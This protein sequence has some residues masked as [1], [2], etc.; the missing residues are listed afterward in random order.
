MLIPIIYFALG[1]LGPISAEQYSYWKFIP[2]QKKTAN[3]QETVAQGYGWRLIWDAAYFMVFVNAL[4]RIVALTAALS[5]FEWLGYLCFLCGVLL[6]IWSLKEIGRFY[7]PGIALKADH[8]MIRTGPYRVLRHPL[9]L[10]TLLQIA[11]L[12]SFAP[13][14]L[15]LPVVLAALALCL[16]LNRT[17]DRAHAQQLGPAF[18]VYYL[19]TWDMIDLIIWKLR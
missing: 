12:A 3:A 7:D 8:Q 13:V 1:I 10:G 2:K 6:R 9:H 18:K 11:G 19:Q 17:E 4:Y 5:I 14:W 16:Y 15:A